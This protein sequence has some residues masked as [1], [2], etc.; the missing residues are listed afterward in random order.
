YVEAM[1][2]EIDT[3]TYY[4]EAKSKEDFEVRMSGKQ[5]GIGARL[6]KRMYNIKII[7]LI[8]GGPAYRSNELEVEDVILK[9]KQEDEE[10]PVNLVGMR[11]D[12]AIKYIKGPKG[13][14]VT[15]TIKKNGWHY[16]R[17]YLG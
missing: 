5:E 15:L 6:Q 9:V 4:F 13:T 10:Y 17:C 14:E 2:S 16:K 12:D 7:E 3:L 1:V 11:I 8:A